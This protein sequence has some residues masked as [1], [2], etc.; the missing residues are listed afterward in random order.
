MRSRIFYLCPCKMVTPIVC[1]IRF[2]NALNVWTI[3]IYG[4]RK[5]VYGGN[6]VNE[7][8]AWKRCMCNQ[9]RTSV[10]DEVLV[11]DFQLISRPLLH[12]ILTKHIGYKKSVLGGSKF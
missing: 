11:T 1:V 10:H 3:E 8:S 6:V 7:S 9:D 5:Q 2:L 12:E 4:Q